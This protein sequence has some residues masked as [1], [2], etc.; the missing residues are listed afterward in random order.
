LIADGRVELQTVTATLPWGEGPSTR[1]SAHHVLRPDVATQLAELR[2]VLRPRSPGAGLPAARRSAI[3]RF[4]PPTYRFYDVAEI[5]ELL[6]GAS[7]TDVEMRV[8]RRS[9]T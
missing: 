1:C 3:A 7:F 8:S 5:T 9:P 4:P 6:A 2:R